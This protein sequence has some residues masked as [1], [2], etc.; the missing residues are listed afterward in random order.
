[1]TNYVRSS[2]PWTLA[3]P[4]CDWRLVVFPRGA[5]GNRPGSGEEAA[6]RGEEHARL[7]HGRTWAE[8]LGAVQPPEEQR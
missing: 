7:T 3:C 6:M 2:P 8:F 1:M 4:W 5:R